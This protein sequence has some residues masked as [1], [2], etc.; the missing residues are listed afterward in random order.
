MDETYEQIYKHFVE[1]AEKL[2]GK[3][4]SYGLT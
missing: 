2:V 3:G 1:V 4:P